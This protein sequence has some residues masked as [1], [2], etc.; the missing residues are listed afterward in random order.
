MA[1]GNLRE[2]VIETQSNMI[3]AAKYDHKRGIL[4]N[5]V[6]IT[7]Q[8]ISRHIIARRIANQCR[9]Q[10]HIW[11]GVLRATLLLLLLLIASLYTFMQTCPQRTAAALVLKLHAMPN[12]RCPCVL[13]GKTYECIVLLA[14][15]LLSSTRY[16]QV[17]SRS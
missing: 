10:R 5:G 15:L 7:V 3:S 4:S 14:V 2:F 13:S 11:C 1:T 12:C 8:Y 6:I 16:V 17:S 9:Q